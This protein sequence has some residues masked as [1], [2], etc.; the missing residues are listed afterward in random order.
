MI[1]AYELHCKKCGNE[2]TDGIL[3]CGIYVCNVC[4]LNWLEQDPPIVECFEC[5]S[6]Q[7]SNFD[8][9]L[10]DKKASGSAY[11]YEIGNPIA[12]ECKKCKTNLS[13]LYNDK[14]FYNV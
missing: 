8:W 4:L 9:Y 12:F 2:D 3:H 10:A 6:D 5:G 11:N 14:S 1:E 13:V 7:T